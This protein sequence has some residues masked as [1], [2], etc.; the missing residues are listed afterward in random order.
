[1]VEAR[2]PKAAQRDYLVVQEPN[3][4]IGSPLLMEA[5]PESRMIF[6]ISD[7]RDVV[8]SAL[9]RHRKGGQAY[10]RLRKDPR[11]GDANR[12]ENDPD[13]ATRGQAKR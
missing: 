9:D 5:L 13:A 12:V 4:S 10:E 7:P 2:F 8:A 6:L 3:G 1:M 11:R